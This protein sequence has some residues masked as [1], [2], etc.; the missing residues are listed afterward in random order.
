MTWRSSAFATMLANNSQETHRARWVGPPITQRPGHGLSDRRNSQR[1][2]ANFSSNDAQSSLSRGITC[3]ACSPVNAWW[4]VAW[5]RSSHLRA[6]HPRMVRPSRRLSGS[7]F[8]H[9]MARTVRRY[10]TCSSPT[11]SAKQRTM[12]HAAHARHNHT[13]R[14]ALSMSERS[15]VCR[16]PGKEFGHTPA[17]KSRARGRSHIRPRALRGQSH[18]DPRSIRG[19][20]VVDPSSSRGRFGVA[21]GSARGRF[22]GR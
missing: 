4:Q 2:C 18:V 17:P 1:G 19:H 12:L 11:T 16:K 13:E 21:S 7:L 9:D 3:Q 20:F 10:E 22:G 14:Q 8:D 15:G 5:T 6:V